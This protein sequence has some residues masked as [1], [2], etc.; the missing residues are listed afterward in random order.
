MATASTKVQLQENLYQF[1]NLLS[2]LETLHNES[3]DKMEN[4]LSDEN[5]SNLISEALD[6]DSRS[7]RIVRLIVEWIG[8]ATIVNGV[9]RQIRPEIEKYID[10]YIE[11]LLSEINIEARIERLITNR[12]SGVSSS[13]NS[14]KYKPTEELSYDS[15]EEIAERMRRNAGDQAWV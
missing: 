13:T 1:D 14:I 7:D 8:Q 4:L 12:S 11:S 3:K 6:E 5:I 15:V 10:V 2:G 9:L